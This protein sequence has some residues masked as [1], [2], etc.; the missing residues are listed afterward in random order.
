MFTEQHLDNILIRQKDYLIN[1]I[2]NHLYEAIPALEVVKELWIACDYTYKL[3][4][5][6][7]RIQSRIQD[8]QQS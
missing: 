6:E 1:L 5:L 3:R 4:E 2:D 8:Q 7:N